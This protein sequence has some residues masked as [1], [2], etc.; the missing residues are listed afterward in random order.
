MKQPLPS[1][2]P[3]NLVLLS[4]EVESNPEIRYLGYELPTARFRLMTCECIP[5]YDGS[6][7]RE[8]RLWHHIRAHGP[9]AGWVE[10]H[11]RQ[12]DRVAL[13][14]KIASFTETDRL[15]NRH[16]VTEITAQKILLLPREEEP[17][18]ELQEEVLR[19][20]APEL[21]W[22]DFA[23]SEGEDPFA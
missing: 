13:E 12:G 18:Q 19:Q 23:P 3:I 5:L 8:Q 22:S 6:G 14:G 21:N 16:F 17:S 4:G 15:G 11:L 7:E 10:E 1:P 9:L 20:E 2:Y